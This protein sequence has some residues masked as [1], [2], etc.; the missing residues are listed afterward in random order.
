MQIRLADIDDVDGILSL[1]YPDF[2]QESVYR[3][4]LTYSNAETTYFF[5]SSIISDNAYTIVLDDNGQINGVCVVVLFRSYYKELEAHVEFF[6]VK[7]DIRGSGASRLLIQAATE[8]A[9]KS[10]AGIIYSMSG[11][12]IDDETDKMYAN[13]HKKFGYKSLLG[14]V[15]VKVLDNE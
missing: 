12:G 15:M 2:F 1:I 3:K 6:Y 11:A 5:K 7:K 9:K 10:G 13:L 8:F 4:H 14:N